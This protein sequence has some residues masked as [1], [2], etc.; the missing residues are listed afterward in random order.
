MDD[1]EWRTTTE[2]PLYEVSSVGNIRRKGS[3]K[4]LTLRTERYIRATLYVEKKPITS[5]VH[6]VVANAF[7]DKVEGKDVIDHIDRNKHNNKVSNLRWTTQRENLWNKPYKG[8]SK[9]AGRS[10]FEVKIRD[11]TGKR[12]YLGTFETEEEASGAYQLAV[13]ELRGQRQ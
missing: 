11:N 5:L 8:Y 4:L 9:K 6:R 13:L 3:D 2:S 7:L 12:L 1:E 10:K